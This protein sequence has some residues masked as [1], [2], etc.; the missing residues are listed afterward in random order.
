M[1][2]AVS[3]EEPDMGKFSLENTQTAPG[4]EP[5]QEDAA[6]RQERLAELARLRMKKE[7]AQCGSVRALLYWL[8]ADGAK[9]A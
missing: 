5:R 4:E 8:R 2:R 9:S 7:I 1:L 6:S 3:D